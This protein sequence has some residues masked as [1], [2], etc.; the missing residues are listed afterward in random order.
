MLRFTPK[1]PH[2]T[3][4]GCGPPSAES[5][6]LSRFGTET[7]PVLRDSKLITIIDNLERRKTEII[8][9]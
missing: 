3:K 5:Y 6:S 9:F 7:T 2:T 1:I 4:G 8:L